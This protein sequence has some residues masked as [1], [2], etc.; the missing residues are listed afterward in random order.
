MPP[1]RPH[2][3]VAADI[4]ELLD[5]LAV[6][7]GTYDGVATCYP[8]PGARRLADIVA[9]LLC[10]LGKTEALTRQGRL[11]SRHRRAV[12]AGPRAFDGCSSRGPTAM[13]IEVWRELCDLG[14]RVGIEVVFVC[15]DPSAWPARLPG[16]LVPIRG[17]GSWLRTP[18]VPT[19]RRRLAQR[20]PMSAS[21][22]LP[23]ACAELLE[24][25][26]RGPGPGDLRRLPP[27][28]LRCPGIGSAPRTR[29][30]GEHAFRS[31]LARTPDARAV[32]L[33]I[34]AVRA[35]GLLRGYDIGVSDIG[36]VNFDDLLTA[37]RLDQ[38]DRLLS[39]EAA[40]VGRAG[41]HVLGVRGSAQYRRQ[42]RMGAAGR[43]LGGRARPRPATAAG[44]AAQRRRQRGARPDSAAARRSR[45]SILW[46]RPPPHSICVSCEPIDCRTFRRIG[47]PPMRWARPPRARRRR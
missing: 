19:S 33:A 7:F 40:A 8:V 10:A 1:D 24:P 16:T 38:L 28:R 25:R 42:Q 43:Q 35:A 15:A 36:G 5:A 30:D 13:A 29:S 22:A 3:S 9:D 37:D 20:F 45:R 11:G 12:A 39:P 18:T 44:V 27:G 31:A 4:A 6:P 47:D 23:A 17:G 21:P 26:A 41:G 14:D 46:T 2:H 32:P 34:H